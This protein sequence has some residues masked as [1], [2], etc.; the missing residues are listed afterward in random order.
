MVDGGVMED[1]HQEWL[2]VDSDN[3]FMFQT[4]KQK[5]IRSHHMNSDNSRNGLIVAKDFNA[6][7]AEFAMLH[8]ADVEVCSLAAGVDVNLSS[9]VRVAKR[10]M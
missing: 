9:A 4:N 2:S 7:K 6:L 1:N 8:I 3:V 5:H 10:G